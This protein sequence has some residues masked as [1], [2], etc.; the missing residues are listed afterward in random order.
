VQSPTHAYTNNTSV[1]PSLQVSYAGVTGCTNSVNK[2]I[3]INK[4]IAP[5]IVADKDAICPS[6][7]ANLSVA[8]SY[9]SIV[10]STGDATA[11]TSI[12]ASGTYTVTA[13]D[14]NG[15]GVTDDIIVAA[16]VVPVIEV[17]AD[18]TAITLGKSVQ[19][20][21]TGADQYVWSPGK[22][23][24]DSLIANPIATPGITTLYT[25]TGTVL[26]GCVAT[27]EIKITIDGSKLSIVVPVGFSPNNDGVN[28]VLAIEGAANY[29]DCVFSIFDG[30]GRR[31]YQAVGNG[32]LWDGTYQGKPV[33]DGVYYFV[34]GCPE[35]KS[36]TGS[37][38]VFR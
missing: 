24:S 23:L 10:W 11:S 29:P 18:Q 12:N 13:V 16:K 32:E 17:S 37:V 3:V 14:T 20:Q 35:G 1:S 36:I 22:T 5:I 28:D 21:A 15:C 19:L 38:L 8:A 33:P 26:T 27:S 7:T 34:F 6:E 25:V 2:T 4:P 30:R 9:T 31:I